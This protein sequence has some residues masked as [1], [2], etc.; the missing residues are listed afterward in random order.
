MLISFGKIEDLSG[1]FL[2][3]LSG[4]LIDQCFNSQPAHRQ[5]KDKEPAYVA[6]Q[7]AGEELKESSQLPA[8]RDNLQEKLDNMNERWNELNAASDSRTTRLDEAVTLTSEYFENR[9]HFVPWLDEAERR[10]DAIQ[11]KCDDE[12][13]ESSK[14]HVEVI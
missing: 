7:A 2:H 5:I 12:V 13:L 3:F 9:C 8:D 10:I 11:L 6:L 4:L 1:A 14:Q